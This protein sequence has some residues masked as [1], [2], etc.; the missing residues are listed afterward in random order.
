VALARGEFSA[1]ISYHSAAGE[2]AYG[3]RITGSW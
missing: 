2:R 1:H 3:I